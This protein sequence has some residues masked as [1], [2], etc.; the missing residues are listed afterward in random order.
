MLGY[1]NTQID[2]EG[3][4]EITEG[5]TLASRF[6]FYRIATSHERR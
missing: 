3:S 1:Y 5:R 4:G 6:A 2:G